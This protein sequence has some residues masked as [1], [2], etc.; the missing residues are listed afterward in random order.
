MN[1]KLCFI[2]A[3]LLSADG[4]S[5]A[6]S[7]ALPI[8][9]TVLSKSNCKFT[10]S[11]ANLDFGTLDP[12]STGDATAKTYINFRCMGSAKVATFTISDVGGL[13][14]NAQQ[15]HRM[16]NS[17]IATEFLPYTLELN[18]TSGSVPKNTEQTL[19]VTGT[20]KAAHYQNAFVGDYQD[21]ATITI[22]P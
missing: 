6:A 10:T 14:D 15:N 1:K 3:L 8:S 22:A 19:T 18:P 2:L 17:G 16:Q 13:N 7:S 20:V 4:I 5:Y 12:G 11:R 21:T 9:A